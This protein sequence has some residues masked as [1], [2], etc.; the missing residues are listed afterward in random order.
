MMQKTI[1]TGLISTAVIFTACDSTPTWNKQDEEQLIENCL[2]AV[3]VNLPQKT[4]E[5]YC[6]CQ[7]EFLKENYESGDEV[8]KET[9]KNPQSLA[10]E[11]QDN[12]LD[13]AKKEAKKSK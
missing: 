1:F 2:H 6:D 13:F 10:R 8:K 11:I 9:E 12:C 7:L 5:I 3:E 4:A